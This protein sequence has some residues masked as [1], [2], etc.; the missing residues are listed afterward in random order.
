MKKILLPLVLI[1][2]YAYSTCYQ[3]FKTTCFANKKLDLVMTYSIG[4]CSPPG[5]PVTHF[6]N[7]EISSLSD[8]SKKIFAKKPIGPSNVVKKQKLINNIPLKAVNGLESL[9][10]ITKTLKG[11]TIT[12]KSELYPELDTDINVELESYKCDA[13]ELKWGRRGDYNPRGGLRVEM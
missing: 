1:S 7:M 2:S 4:G 9:L 5:G 11:H 3:G 10:V 13:V 8:S 12:L 6:S